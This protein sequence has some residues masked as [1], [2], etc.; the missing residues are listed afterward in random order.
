VDDQ[1]NRVYKQIMSS[2]AIGN[3]NKSIIREE[4]RAW[5]KNRDRLCGQYL[6]NKTKMMACN[7]DVTV[8]KVLELSNLDLKI[9]TSRKPFEGEWT[10]CYDKFCLYYFTVVDGENICGTWQEAR[11][12][13][14]WKTNGRALFRAVDSGYAIAQKACAELGSYRT[15]ECEYSKNGTRFDT[16]FSEWTK[17]HGGEIVIS[18]IVRDSDKRVEYAQEERDNL[19]KKTKWL[20]DCL[21]YK[22]E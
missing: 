6:G 5:L 8:P 2:P 17:L 19:I 1:L 7:L 18:S 20:Q 15:P 13:G 10:V 12:D 4:Q 9:N 22:G 14:D 16:N 11:G 21:N 3:A